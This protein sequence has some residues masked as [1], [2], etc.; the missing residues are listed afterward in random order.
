MQTD[1]AQNIQ[2]QQ[3][4]NNNLNNN[5]YLESITR[6]GPKRLHILQMYMFSRFKAR[7]HAGNATHT[8]THT[9][10]LSLSLSHAHT[11]VHTPRERERERQTERD[12]QRQR[13]KVTGREGGAGGQ[14]KLTELDQTF[15]LNSLGQSH[16][17]EGS[18][19]V[20]KVRVVVF[21]FPLKSKLTWSKSSKW[22]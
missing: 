13:Q 10:T 18:S 2:Q 21:A 22:G 9:H 6:T 15:P 14:K 8:H 20:N 16:Q 3:Q 11:H 12:R 5:G 4:N 19:K 1:H 7:M 17:S